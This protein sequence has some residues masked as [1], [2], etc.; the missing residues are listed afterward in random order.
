MT[1]EPSGQPLRQFKR[2]LDL[3]IGRDHKRNHIGLRDEPTEPILPRRAV[4]V[5]RRGELI[6]HSIRGKPRLRALIVYLR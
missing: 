6:K 1:R 2:A 3:P 4:A 5:A